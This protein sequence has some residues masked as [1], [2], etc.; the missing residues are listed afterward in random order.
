M[1]VKVLENCCNEKLGVQ[2]ENVF[3]LWIFEITL[4]TVSERKD[5]EQRVPVTMS[6]GHWRVQILRKFLACVHSDQAR[7]TYCLQLKG[8]IHFA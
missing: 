2:T 4:V 5:S 7:S 8:A 3:L 6:T 1:L